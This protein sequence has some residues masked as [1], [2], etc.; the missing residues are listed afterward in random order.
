MGV[1]ATCAHHGPAARAAKAHAEQFADERAKVAP[2]RNPDGDNWV[3]GDAPSQALSWAVSALAKAGTLSI[4]GVYPTSATTF[5]IGEA[6]NKNLTVNM[7]N[8]NHRKYIPELISLVQTEAFR[9]S[10]ILTNSLTLGEAIDAY[11][12]FDR[13]APGWTKVELRVAA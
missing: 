7:G 8:C 2:D 12:A 11:R 1:D 10:T 3:P 13:R 5:P 9:P 6:M 4:V